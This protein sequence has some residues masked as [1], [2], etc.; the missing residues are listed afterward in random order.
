MDRDLTRSPLKTIVSEGLREP[1]KAS[2]LTNRVRRLRKKLD[3]GKGLER[4]QETRKARS[5]YQGRI[6]QPNDP[7]HQR[8]SA[9]GPQRLAPEKRGPFGRLRKR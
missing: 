6:R 4:R 7:R 8:G 5:R 2:A 9:K 3:I 1:Y